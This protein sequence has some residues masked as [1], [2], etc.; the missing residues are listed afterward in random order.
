MGE[1]DEAFPLID[2]M[3]K[4]NYTIDVKTKKAKEAVKKSEHKWLKAC[5]ATIMF[6][7]CGTLY[8]TNHAEIAR[9]LLA[10][11]GV[12]YTTKCMYDLV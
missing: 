1:G 5:A 6:I 4:L 2:K 10:I 8:I 9:D 7:L 3:D 11:I 12:C